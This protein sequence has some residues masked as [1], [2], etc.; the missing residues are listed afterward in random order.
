MRFSRVPRS[1]AEE[2]D[3][4]AAVKDVA[5]LGLLAAEAS[6]FTWE[7]EAWRK[8]GKALSDLGA[9]PTAVRTLE[10]IS[11]V[12]ADIA[13]VEAKGDRIGAPLDMS[14]PFRQKG[15]APS[16]HVV[17]FTGH[18]IDQP[19]RPQPRFPQSCV[20]A[21]RAEIRARLTRLAP[22]LGIAA[23]ASGGDILFHE[24]CAGLNIR[25]EVCLVMP[26]RN[27]VNASVVDAGP[28]WVERYWTLIHAK[29]KEGRL[30]QLN[31]GHELPAWLRGKRDY[32]IWNRANLW[33]LERALAMVPARL[34][35]MAL[36]DGKDRGDGPGGTGDL[37]ARAT[38]L[39]AT[40]DVI[41]TETL[42]P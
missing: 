36:W 7:V 9:W 18:R 14:A 13:D 19:G 16:A 4:A 25:T 35:V 42:C 39:S 33:M 8:V 5:Y 40:T 26:P 24:L 31:D 21:A 30:I 23:A 32:E 12:A 37:L 29:Q 15:E 6:G 41:S 3:R 2:V 20:G 22:S 17:V 10:R 1:F 28:D 38:E 27:F 11:N 34:T